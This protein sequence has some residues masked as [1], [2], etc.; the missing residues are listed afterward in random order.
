MVKFSRK[1]KVAFPN[2]SFAKSNQIPIMFIGFR[3]RPENM[4]IIELVSLAVALS[5]KNVVSRFRSLYRE[6]DLQ[7]R[8]RNFCKISKSYLFTVH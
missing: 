1:S 3:D 7:D 8:K 2:C 4:K 6:L 5:D